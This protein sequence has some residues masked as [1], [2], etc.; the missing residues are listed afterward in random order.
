MIKK[1]EYDID[2]KCDIRDIKFILYDEEDKMFYILCNRKSGIIGFFLFKIAENN[3]TYYKDKKY[4]V[5]FVNKLSSIYEVIQVTYKP[6]DKNYI[7]EAVE[8]LIDF[9]NDMSSCNR[10]K[11]K[12][13]D[14]IVLLVEDYDIVEDKG[15]HEADTFGKSEAFSTWIYP[16]NGGYI[17]ITCSDYSEEANKEN[18]WT[19]QLSVV[20]GSEKLKEFLMNE[21]YN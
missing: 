15:E 14:E 6:N 2:A 19:D 4:V 12:I 16:K 18:G 5:V 20:V 13:T 1:K 7:I 10:L 17:A 3:P 9:P 21:A 8:G 11:K